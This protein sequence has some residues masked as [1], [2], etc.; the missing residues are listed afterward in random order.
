MTDQ[1]LAMAA[2]FQLS[3]V[4]LEGEL[5]GVGLATATELEVKTKDLTEG[6]RAA[7]RRRVV[8]PRM[9]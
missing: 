7:E 3:V 4:I 2:S 9:V 1:A 6:V 8:T 5:S